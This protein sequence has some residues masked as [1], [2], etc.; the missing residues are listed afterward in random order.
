MN[1]RMAV[2]VEWRRIS[3]LWSHG[4]LKDLTLAEA[5]LIAVFHRIQL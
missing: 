4:T 3:R 5:A 1:L 2:V